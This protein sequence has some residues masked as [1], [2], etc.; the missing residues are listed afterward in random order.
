MN[1]DNHLF[2]ISLVQEQVIYIFIHT[3][4]NIIASKH[5]VLSKLPT[6]VMAENG[7]RCDKVM[8]A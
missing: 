2:I 1:K 4:V 5:F 8:H 7:E 3:E 6:Q